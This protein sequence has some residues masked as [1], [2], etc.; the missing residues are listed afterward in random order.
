MEWT[1]EQKAAIDYRK[2]T[3]LVSAAA[4][5]GKT[6]VL[7]QRILDWIMK[8]N[9]NI[10]EFLVV[11]FTRAAAAQ[12]RTKLRNAL[13]E[14]QEKYPGDQ[15]L[16]RQLSLIHRASITT[17]DS[18]CKEIVDDHFQTLGLDPTMRIMDETEGI[19][20][21]EDV[22]ERILEQAYERN[23]EALLDLHQ[24]MNDLRT[25]DNIRKLLRELQRQANSFPEPEKWL[26]NAREDVLALEPEKLEKQP[27][28]RLLVKEIQSAMAE[29]QDLPGQIRSGYQMLE[30]EYRPKAYDKYC[31]YLLEEEQRIEQIMK[32]TSYRELYEA[33]DDSQRVYKR[34]IWKNS[35]VPEEHYLTELW[36]TYRRMKKE[37]AAH[38]TLSLSELLIQQQGVAPVLLTILDLTE[39]FMKEYQKEKLERNCMDFS[40]VEHYAFQVLSMGMQEGRP[41]PTE[42]ARQLQA[43]Y[44]EILIDEYQDSND[45]QEAIL[46]SVAKQEQGEYT[47]LFM[48]GDSK[49]SIYRFRMA[50]PQ[51]FQEKYRSFSPDLDGPDRSCRI[52]L[53]ENFRSRETVLEAVNLFFYQLMM[54]SLGG[55]QYDRRVALIPG[56]IFPAEKEAGDYRTELVLLD[57]DYQKP[58]QEKSDAVEDIKEAD[59]QN[60]EEDEP[61]REQKIEQE[62]RLAAARIHELCDSLNPLPIWNEEQGTYCPCRYKDI[63]ILFRTAKGWSEIFSRVLADEGIP[64]YADNG[65][66]YF[67]SVEVK[68]LLCMLSVIDN[69]RDDI[70]L[71]G[72]LRS[73]FAS[74]SSEE[75]A[76]IRG[77]CR[78]GD[79]WT[80]IQNYGMQK[81]A[82][83]ELKEKLERFCHGVKRW[84]ELKTYSTIRELIWDILNTTGY[85]DYVGAMPGGARRQGNLVRLMEKASSYE[86]TS[87]HGLFDF[88]RYI[89]KMKVTEQDFGETAVIS[90]EDD[91]VRIMTIHKS[92]GLE[93]PVVLLCG[94]GKMFNQQDTKD[95]VLVDADGYLGV[96]YKYLDKHYF[97]KTEKRNCLA[98][99]IKEENLAEELRV[100]YV[101]MTRAKEKLILIGSVDKLT[102]QK[103][104]DYQ[105]LYDSYI[106]GN[107]KDDLLS[108]KEEGMPLPLERHLVETG[109]SYLS[110]LIPCMVRL[111]HLQQTRKYLI[112]RIVK[113]EELDVH[114]EEEFDRLAEREARWEEY[115]SYEGAREVEEEIRK[116][117]EW[118]YAYPLAATCKGKLSVS[119]IKKMSQ[120]IDEPDRDVADIAG[121]IFPAQNGRP[122]TFDANEKEEG[123]MDGAAYGTLLHLVMEKIPFHCMETKAKVQEAIET[124]KQQNIITEEEYPYISVDKIFDMIQSALGKRMQEAEKKGRLYREQQ[125]VI[126]I[127]MNRIYPEAEET[128]L[129]LVQGI[130]DAYFEEKDELIL[131]D[132]KTDTVDAETGET[133][134]LRR[135][136]AQLEYYKYTLEQLTGK[137]VKEVYLYSFCL[138]K[139]IPVPAEG[140]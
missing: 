84:K 74:V 90:G 112:Y 34:F 119:E 116:R 78:T 109:K 23:A 88:L 51:L 85:Y 132:Y 12:M 57:N 94:C 98:R 82:R 133:T 76:C 81:N 16:V 14:L 44:T 71:A 56:R 75:L 100:L 59:S 48:V 131:L 47:N 36:E 8:D 38:V 1:K 40:D 108:G 129:E 105:F 134:L 91:M 77:L 9:K 101:A 118:K 114:V 83:P 136:H 97:E 125:F 26:E 66:G 95:T 92:K 124:M 45:L 111:F 50:R 80:A 54:E 17:I 33:Y 19:L 30:A 11:T 24:Y 28:V 123:K 72:S 126:G 128:D 68:N 63:V 42:A 99:H 7:V 13:E 87:Y 115:V 102:A 20:L 2:G 69:A 64:V 21:K 10:D 3:L 110:W 138:G 22:L 39:A 29:V 120:M 25:D 35:G 58:E 127:P 122:Q 18:F 5:S 79:L 46:T 65:K 15:H 103:N 37:T 96:N 53:K 52:E 89:E 6:A 137:N 135:Y 113:K 140:I 43:A 60:E 70:A 41:V 49:Q 31:Q 107:T 121:Q 61:D 62:A 139:T 67:D 117:F 4:G 27:W 93:F 104:P 55:I 106:E 73:P 130:I 86:K 32:A